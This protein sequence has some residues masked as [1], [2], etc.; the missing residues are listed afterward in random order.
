MRLFV[1][2]CLFLCLFSTLF[3]MEKTLT[4]EEVRSRF[5]LYVNNY[6]RENG[7]EDLE[8]MYSFIAQEHANNQASKDKYLAHRGFN[9]RAN[10]IME[11]VKQ[12]SLTQNNSFGFVSVVENCCYFQICIDPAKKAFELFVA[13]PFHRF[14]LLK[15]CQYTAIG[16][17]QGESGQFYFCQILF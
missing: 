7:L 11:Y 2:F 13:S 16:I 10:L 6:R 14:N 12:E 8:Q 1:F 4:L 3:G 17:G 5:L 9:I 15:K